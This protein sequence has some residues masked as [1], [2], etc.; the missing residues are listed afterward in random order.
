MEP[1]KYQVYSISVSRICLGLLFLIIGA[2][3]IL[4]IDSNHQAGVL[5][6]LPYFVLTGIPPA[7]FGVGIL[8]H[9]LF[10]SFKFTLSR[11]NSHIQVEE[12]FVFRRLKTLPIEE[13]QAIKLGDT[14]TRYKYA[15]M[16]LWLVY[17]IFTLESGFHQLNLLYGIIMIGSGISVLVL[18]FLLV[19]AT[20]KEV[21]IETQNRK[22]WA[23]IT[24]LDM[25]QL[26]Q[27]LQIPLNPPEKSQS[28]QFKDYETLV[29][30]T[31][32]VGLALLIHFVMPFGTF[33]DLF[34]LIY[35][36]KLILGTLQ[37][38]WGSFTTI[39]EEAHLLVRIKGF[40]YNK[41]YY[42]KDISH[43]TPIR[44][45]KAIHPLEL[46]IIGVLF[47]LT[48]NATLRA[49]FLENWMFFLQALLFTSCILFAVT[50][51]IFRLENYL[52]PTSTS[53]LRLPIFQGTIALKRG[54]SKRRLSKYLE[55]I[56]QSSQ[57]NGFYW[58]LGFLFLLIFI[59]L[60]IFTAF[61]PFL[62]WDEFFSW[63]I[64]CAL[65]K[66]QYWEKEYRTEDIAGIGQIDF[67]RGILCR[68]SSS[69][70]IYSMFPFRFSI[71][72]NISPLRGAKTS[73]RVPMHTS[74]NRRFS[75]FCSLSYP[76]GA[77][78]ESRAST[79]PTRS[80]SFDLL[81]YI[82]SLTRYIK[83]SFWRT[84]KIARPRYPIF[85]R[86]VSIFS[87]PFHCRYPSYSQRECLVSRYPPRQNLFEV[88][89]L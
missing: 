24:K 29:I 33:I 55:T 80:A 65:S 2:I 75:V 48:I 56:V 42:F 77:L 31:L 49:A 45:L 37:T 41:M 44:K 46:A 84:F 76:Q 16:G 39:Q 36:T 78:T 30:G 20:R 28:Y 70:A 67:L 18:I 14:T 8:Y 81:P 25:I 83:S 19:L 51:Y 63:K 26:S 11:V 23:N 10:T 82:F 38:A 6:P 3:N 71:Y 21:T 89:S 4:F 57:I 35:G 22:V 88:L 9:I 69:F 86:F 59:P 13:I 32:F 64:D 79:L 17:V 72:G 62:V 52:T 40:R 47:F 73:L 43:R 68:S 74:L 85:Y 60:L 34:L 87:L 58:R 12:K 53:S 5:F 50:L 66:F 54:E 7:L 15:L 27:I 1:Q 61:F